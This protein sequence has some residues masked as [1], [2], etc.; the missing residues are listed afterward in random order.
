MKKVYTTE[1]MEIAKEYFVHKMPEVYLILSTGLRR[2]EMLGLKWSDIDLSEDKLSVNRSISA[3]KGGGYREGPPKWNSYRDIPI[4][5]GLKNLLQ[6]LPH[7]SEY[8]FPN[9]NGIGCQLP[10]AWSRK[11][12]RYMVK[13]NDEF[14]IPILSA[15]ELR[16]T[17]GTELRRRGIDIYTIQ[18]IMGHKDIQMTTEIYVHNEFEMLKKALLNA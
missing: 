14:G 11:L 6:T 4:E 7:N 3:K 2:S 17:Y 8:L 12:R 15:H 5:P 10:C 16:H 13:L 9:Q 1:E 18:K